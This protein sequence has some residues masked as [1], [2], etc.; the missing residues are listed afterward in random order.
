MHLMVESVEPKDRENL[1][2]SLTGPLRTMGPAINREDLDAPDWWH[3]DEEAS[4]SM[5]AALGQE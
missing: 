2:K 1:A 5:L 3:G 4:Q